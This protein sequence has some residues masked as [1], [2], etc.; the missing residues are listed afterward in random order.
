MF[1][2]L[3]GE[4][5]RIVQSLKTVRQGVTWQAGPRVR[6]K[7]SDLRASDPAALKVDRRRMNT[8]I[9]CIQY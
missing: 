2:T 1:G 6:F 7:R 8:K 9:H 4:L 3:E 5:V